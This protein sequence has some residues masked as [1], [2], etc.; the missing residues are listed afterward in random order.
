M[1][2]KDYIDLKDVVR[3]Q[4]DMPPANIELMMKHHSYAFQTFFDAVLG[5]SSGEVIDTVIAI[6]YNYGNKESPD[7]VTNEQLTSILHSLQYASEYFD[8]L[9]DVKNRWKSFEKTVIN[10]V[11]CESCRCGH[12]SETY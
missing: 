9:D 11:H 6:V 2:I 7:N 10:Q 1:T 3:Y 12:E 8:G 4:M 5:H